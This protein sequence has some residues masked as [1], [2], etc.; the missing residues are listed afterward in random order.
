MEAESHTV[1]FKK[2][3]LMTGAERGGV[4]KE[5]APRQ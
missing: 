5:Q 4:R 1:L 2:C 3:S